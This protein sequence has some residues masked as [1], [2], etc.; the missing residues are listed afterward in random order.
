MKFESDKS[1]HYYSNFFRQGILMDTSPLIIYFLGE[2]DKKHKT[3]LI[4]KWKKG[5]EPYTFLDYDYLKNFLGTIPF[6]RLCITPHIFHEFYKHLQKILDNKF[7][8]FFNYNIDLLMKLH[9]KNVDKNDL[10]THNFFDKLEIGEHSLYM[11]KEKEQ[12][13]VILTDD[14]RKTLPIFEN[15]K[16]VLL[17]FIKDIINYMNNPPP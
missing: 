4:E 3:S 15:D 10:M 9:E 14:E 2:Y 11:V 6:E 7:H 17:V 8:K 5:N 12:P 1:I 16:E 13:C